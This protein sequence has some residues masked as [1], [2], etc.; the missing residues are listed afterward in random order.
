MNTKTF[1]RGAWLLP[2]AVFFSG[3]TKTE[4]P[5]QYIKT[6]MISCSFRGTDALPVRIEVESS[7]NA[8]KAEASATWIRITEQT[9]SYIVLNADDNPD[10]TEREGEVTIQAGSLTRTIRVTQASDIRLQSSYYSFKDYTMGAVISPNARYAGGYIGI[11]D[12]NDRN[13]WILNVVVTDLRDGKEYWLEPFSQNL[14]ALYDPCAVTDGGDIFFHCED[15]RIVCFGL[16]GDITVLDNVPGAGKPWVSQ[17]ASDESGVWVGWCSG[18]ETVY[19]PVKWTDGTPQILS[20]PETTYRGGEWYQGCMARGC[21]LDGSIVYGT[22]WE[23][24]DAGLIWWDASGTPRWVGEKV[25]EIKPVKMLDPKTQEYYDYNLVDGIMGDGTST[26]ISPSGKWIAGTYRTEELDE[27][28]TGIVATSC[29]A[30]YDTENDEVYLFPEFEGA[31]GLTVTDDGVGVVGIGATSGILTSTLM[32]D[33]TAG[34]ELG[35][36]TDWIYDNL[37]IIIPDGSYLTY[38]SPDGATA[39]GYDL[40]GEVEMMRMWCVAPKP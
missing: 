7:P 8:W 13:Q 26:C 11:L 40:K 9:D 28:E 31:A 39:F 5:D 22:A 20:K 19:S 38:I 21:S 24:F 1:C 16:S 3:C 17:V 14:Y 12:E 30:F 15:G 2:L 35:S 27:Q 33:I 6:D 37:G 18:G 23:G 29:P 25:R 36:S 34:V 32:V 10:S 4:N